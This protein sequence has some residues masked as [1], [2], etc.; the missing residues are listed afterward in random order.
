MEVT[1]QRPSLCTV[2]LVAVVALW[3][4][5]AAAQVE[6]GVQTGAAAG[7]PATEGFRASVPGDIDFDD[8]TQPCNFVSTVA[9]TTEYSA[10][11]V[12]FTGPGGNDGGA[13]L[14]ECGNF[15]ATGYSPPN[16]LAFNVNS[17]LSNGGIPRG[18][19]TLT[20]SQPVTTVAIRGGHGSSGSITLEC[21][22]GA[23]ATVGS[24]TVAGTVALQPLTVTASGQIASCRLSFTGT[25]AVFDD[26]TYDPPIP[27]ELVSFSVD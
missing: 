8:G 20:F 7:T 5:P 18:P 19:E 14:D 16:F 2:G 10:L 24:Q 15:T 11:G 22:N 1:M 21:F 12:V 26:L 23:G 17:S 9:I 27:V 6:N 25:V 13:I 3:A 4:G